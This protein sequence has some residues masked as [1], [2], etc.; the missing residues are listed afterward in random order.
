[1]TWKRWGGWKAHLYDGD[2]CLCP[3]V[4]KLHAQGIRLGPSAPKLAEV[5]GADLMPDGIPYASCSRCRKQAKTPQP[6]VDF[7]EG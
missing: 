2:T 5:T 3:R 1:M 4:G 7:A 6:F